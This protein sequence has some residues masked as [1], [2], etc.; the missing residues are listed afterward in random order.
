MSKKRKKHISLFDRRTKVLFLKIATVITALIVVVAISIYAV[1]S[2]S[3]NHQQIT[4][5]KEYQPSD[6]IANSIKMN[7]NVQQGT[8]DSVNLSDSELISSDS[9]T[10]ENNETDASN[11]TTKSVDVQN[12]NISEISQN[13]NSSSIDLVP[14]ETSDAEPTDTVQDDQQNVD[15]TLA[16]YEDTEIPNGLTEEEQIQYVKDKWVDD[17]IH[18]NSSEIDQT[19]LSQG[20]SIY[21]SLDTEYLFGLAKDGLTTEEKTQAEAYL[22]AQLGPEQFELAM[23]LY[24]KYVGLVN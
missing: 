17:M 24:N 22:N 16:D 13:T 10:T 12:Q 8:S 6:E 5:T 11:S 1:G 2:K 4:I 18:E 20:A 7:E 19:D 23:L 3:K 9:S 15:E 21:N 14:D